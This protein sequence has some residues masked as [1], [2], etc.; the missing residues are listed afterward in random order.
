[1][2]PEVL[3]VKFS[4]SHRETGRVNNVRWLHST[5]ATKSSTNISSA[6]NNLCCLSAADNPARE[7]VA[8][9]K[10]VGARNICIFNLK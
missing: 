3:L 1:V 7:Q 9:G 8:V 6:Y 2:Q 5:A 10:N 4:T